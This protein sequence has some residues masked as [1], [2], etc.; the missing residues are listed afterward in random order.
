MDL[1]TKQ[2]IKPELAIIKKREKKYKCRDHFKK[3]N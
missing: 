3:R 2:R 1:V